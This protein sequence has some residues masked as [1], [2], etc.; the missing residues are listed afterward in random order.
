MDKEEIIIISVSI[1][2]ISYF[3]M[4]LNF[5]K[6]NYLDTSYILFGITIVLFFIIS[7]K[8]KYR[9]FIFIN[10]IIFG[11]YVFILVY[12]ISN[13]FLKYL[14]LFV[15]IIVVLLWCI[16]KDCILIQ[17]ENRPQ[18]LNAIYS[19]PLLFFILTVSCFVYSIYSLF[20]K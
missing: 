2:I 13:K 11:I 6:L 20:Y 14:N 12:F 3:L 17:Y 7:I 19:S 4:V 5:Q 16:Y 18:N 9:N 10:H 8:Y 15:L 1:F